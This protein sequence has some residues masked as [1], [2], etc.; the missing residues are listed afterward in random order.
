[1]HVSVYK[2]I[3]GTKKTKTKKNKKP[4]PSLKGGNVWLVDRLIVHM[5]SEPFIFEREKDHC[6]LHVMILILGD[7]LW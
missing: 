5:V 2:F 3:A 7:N 4:W 6:C 1:M